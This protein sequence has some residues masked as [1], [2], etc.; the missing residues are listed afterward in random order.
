MKRR[1]DKTTLVYSIVCNIDDDDDDGDDDVALDE[2]DG[3]SLP[4]SPFISRRARMIPCALNLA[5][6][7]ACLLAR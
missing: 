6:R 7:D 4:K 3:W 5:L 2:W 1:D